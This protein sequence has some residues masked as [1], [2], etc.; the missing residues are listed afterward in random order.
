MHAISFCLTH[1]SLII[2]QSAFILH[3]F[4]DIFILPQA[5]YYSLLE[6]WP[7]WA[8][9]I[10]RCPSFTILADILNIVSIFPHNVI[11]FSRIIVMGGGS[12]NFNKQ[13]TRFNFS[14]TSQTKHRTEVFFSTG[15]ASTAVFFTLIAERGKVFSWTT[16]GILP[17]NI[18]LCRK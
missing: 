18:T 6:F 13:T 12:Y 2:H 17:F 9:N 10:N 15:F 4:G 5:F 16:S 1:I 7:I 14:G 8:Q 3:H 11:D